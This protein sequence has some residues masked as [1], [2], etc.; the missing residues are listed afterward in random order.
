MVRIDS[1]Y[2]ILKQ[3]VLS[4][5][6]DLILY[7]KNSNFLGMGKSEL[8]LLGFE[9][10]EDFKSNFDDFADLFISRPGY[11]SKFKNF[12]W[13]D[14]A[15]HSGTPNKKILM[16]HKNGTEIEG[17][18]IIHEIELIQENS[19]MYCIEIATTLAS[20]D[21]NI[22]TDI[23]FSS[24]EEKINENKETEK[25]QHNEITQTFDDILAEDQDKI[26]DK[27]EEADKSIHLKINDEIKDIED[28]FKLQI[29]DD[30][31]TNPKFNIE[32][33]S[34][35]ITDDDQ[36]IKLKVDFDEN[37][38]FDDITT[39]P[40][41]IKNQENDIADITL[42]T[43]QEPSEDILPKEVEYENIDFM[44]I[45]EDTGLDLGDIAEII[46]DFVQES[47]DYIKKSNKDI[48]DID[49]I[50]NEAI[51]LKGITSNLKMTKITNTLN[52]ILENS[53]SNEEKTLLES[54][55]KQI[56]NLKE[57]LL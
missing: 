4:K 43:K 38:D 36:P 44:K 22:K 16:K 45:A 8:S 14:Y 31:D 54:F 55:Q 46:E 27:N 21:Y 3:I 23:D 18:V 53:N 50:K 35:K 39:T 11:I 30:Y 28:D 37:E 15:L 5:G 56:N 52:L 9:D 17:K 49:F 13:I 33:D 24:L 51:K 1:W 25:S 40:A 34:A 2:F 6:L 42:D 57:Q 19:R 48:L 32:T 20:T 29:E 26:D 7:D 10:M 47:E 41:E 12:S